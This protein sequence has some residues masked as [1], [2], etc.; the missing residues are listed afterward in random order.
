MGSE[1]GLREPGAESLGAHA[2]HFDLFVAG[3][4]STDELEPVAGAIE[5][6][7]QEAKDGF[8]GRGV[9]GGSGDF[10][11]QFGAGRADDLIFG[12]AGLYLQGDQNAIGVDLEKAWFHREHACL[13]SAARL[14]NRVEIGRRIGNS[15]RNWK[16]P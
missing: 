16:H 10:D 3:L 2:E 6:L 12:G 7:G 11:A 9:H 8:I 15:Q 1:R 14:R 4:V 13:W 5:D